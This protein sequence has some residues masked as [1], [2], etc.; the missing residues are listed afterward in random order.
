[1]RDIQRD[2]ITTAVVRSFAGARDARLQHLLERL[3][4]HLHAF[5]RET[6]LTHEEWRAGI[7]FLYRAGK[8]S[9]ESRNEFILLSDVLGLS[10]LVDLLHGAPGATDGSV[11]GPFHTADSRMVDPGAD[12]IGG[13]GGEPVY[14]HGRV[15]D[16]AGA[17]IAGATLDF[18]QAAASGLYWQQD[19]T[20]DPHNLRCRMTTGADGGYALKTVRPAA[21]SVPYDGPVGDLLRNGG[22]HAWRPAHF[23]FIV[24]APGFASLVTEVF[25]ADDRYADEDAVFGVRAALCV[26]FRRND[27]PEDAARL[28]MATPFSDVAF[29]FRLAAA[30]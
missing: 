4:S 28:G 8:I 17:P 13:N 19:P 22:R 12:L 30:R 9:T 21:Y 6:G 3:V 20:Q 27:S 16:T 7:D 2:N 14:L 26:E 15:L 24:S 25:P 1:M 23:H 10:S 11:L 18:W 29:D 5:A